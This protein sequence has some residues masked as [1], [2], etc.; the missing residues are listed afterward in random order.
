MYLNAD[1]PLLDDNLTARMTYMKDY[2]GI[3]TAV[4]V[5]YFPNDGVNKIVTDN[6]MYELLQNYTEMS[7]KGFS[8][9]LLGN[10]NGRCLKRCDFTKLNVI[11]NLPFYNGTRLRQ[12]VEASELSLANCLSCCIYIYIYNKHAWKSTK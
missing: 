2:G 3:Q 8:V 5:V 7:S 12:F 6:L 4:D 1:T 11:S 9:V 10:F